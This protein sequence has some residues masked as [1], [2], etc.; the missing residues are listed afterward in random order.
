MK[1]Y[2]MMDVVIVQYILSYLKSN[3]I[4]EILKY[5]NHKEF[6]SILRHLIENMHKIKIIYNLLKFIDPKQ[7]IKILIEYNS[8]MYT[9]EWGKC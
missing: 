9:I 7:S 3:K 1:F 2:K 5:L 8:L 4:R 6:I